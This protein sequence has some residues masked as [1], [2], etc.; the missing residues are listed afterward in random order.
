MTPPEYAFDAMIRRTA[1]PLAMLAFAFGAFA[2]AAWDMAD[3]N[4]LGG[5]Y[6]VALALVALRAHGR[7]VTA[8]AA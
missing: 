7:V 8:G 5:V 1:L 6:F 2:W 4:D 3:G